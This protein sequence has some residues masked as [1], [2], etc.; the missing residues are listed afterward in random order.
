MANPNTVNTKST[1]IEVVVA[2]SN[3]LPKEAT[4]DEVDVHWHFNWAE[5]ELTQPAVYSLYDQA[6]LGKRVQTS[7]FVTPPEPSPVQLTAAARSRRILGALHRLSPTHVSA[8]ARWTAPPVRY[9]E[10]VFSLFGRLSAVAALTEAFDEIGGSAAYVDA[11]RRA[12]GKRDK[13]DGTA[14]FLR[15]A[16][17]VKLDVV[18]EQAEALL[19]EAFAAYASARAAVDAETAAAARNK[20]T[21]R[22]PHLVSVTERVAARTTEPLAPAS[23]AMARLRAKRDAR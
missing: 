15:H 5:G 6:L 10:P 12:S 17:R 7:A 20:R 9:P 16:A 4:R 3:V 13:E 14:N 18:R 8:L 11:C 19:R 22:T 1:E 21:T 23:S 2:A